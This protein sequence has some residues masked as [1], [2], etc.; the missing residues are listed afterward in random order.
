MTSA[1]LCYVMLRTLLFCGDASPSF[2]NAADN[3]A[4]SDSENQ[5]GGE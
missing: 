4:S 3:T 5:I 1:M 2:S